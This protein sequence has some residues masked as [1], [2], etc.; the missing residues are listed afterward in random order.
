[1]KGTVIYCTYAGNLFK[2]IYANSFACIL[3]SID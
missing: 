3:S 1:M 2:L